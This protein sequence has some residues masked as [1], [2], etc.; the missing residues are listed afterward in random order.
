MGRW[1][2]TVTEDM[3]ILSPT[4]CELDPAVKNTLAVGRL[5][6]AL[7]RCQD[8]MDLTSVYTREWA[9]LRLVERRHDGC[10]GREAD[11]AHTSSGGFNPHFLALSHRCNLVTPT[12]GPY[13]DDKS[14]TRRISER[15]V[16]EN[17]VWQSRC[18]HELTVDVVVCSGAGMYFSSAY[19]RDRVLKIRDIQRF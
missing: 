7:S 8:R 5:I 11:L 1:Q 13:F 10:L 3:Q 16:S 9:R 18:H 6:L 14:K 17:Q 4:S 12:H 15:A 2:V 19:G